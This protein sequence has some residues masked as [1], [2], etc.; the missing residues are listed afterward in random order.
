MVIYDCT[1]Q[2]SFK[3]IRS[4]IKQ[5]EL[6]GS[7]RRQQLIIGN[8]CDRINKVIEAQQGAEL[9]KEFDFSFFETSAKTGYNV[10][11]AF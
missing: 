1:S 7:N 2:N 8:K 11:E 3:S 6:Y 5:C 10:D 9:A 4:Y